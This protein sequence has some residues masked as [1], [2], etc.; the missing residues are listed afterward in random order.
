ML[1][2]SPENMRV[3]REAGWSKARFREELDEALTVDG[4]AK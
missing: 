3:F 4:E 1:V 2:I